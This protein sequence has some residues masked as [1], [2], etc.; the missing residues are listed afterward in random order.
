MAAGAAGASVVAGAAGASVVAGAA[1]ASVVA[2]VTLIDRGGGA[3]HPRAQGQEYREQTQPTHRQI[4]EEAGHAGTC[5]E[6]CAPDRRDGSRGSSDLFLRER[7]LH[8]GVF[9]PVGHLSYTQR[10][11]DRCPS[12]NPPPDIVDFPRDPWR[13]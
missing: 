3:G 8:R 7:L 5:C 11:P 10:G 2:A 6:N 4:A 9:P 13:G 1:G 12:P